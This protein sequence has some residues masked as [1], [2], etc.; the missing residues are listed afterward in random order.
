MSTVSTVVSS[1]TALSI[2]EEEE[3]GDYLSMSGLPVDQFTSVTSTNFT[4]SPHLYENIAQN[5]PSSS[6]SDPMGSCNPDHKTAAPPTQ[7]TPPPTAPPTQGTPV[8]T[9]PPTQG[10]PLSSTSETASLLPAAVERLKSAATT[11]GV[12]G[13]QP[14]TP[15][16]KMARKKWRLA[17]DKVTPED[18]PKILCKGCAALFYVDN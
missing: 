10:T 9:A 6:P 3:E 15:E 17:V 18:K 4:P 7:R 1:V 5:D 12:G 13:D 11:T 14:N 16:W 8:S 2:T